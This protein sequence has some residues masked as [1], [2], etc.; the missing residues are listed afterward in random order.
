MIIDVNNLKGGS[1]IQSPFFII[2][3]ILLILILIAVI[4]YLIFFNCKEKGVKIIDKNGILFRRENCIEKELKNSEI[5][6]YIK[7]IGMDML[8]KKSKSERLK[9]EAE[10]KIIENED[11]LRK[12]KKSKNI[13]NN[14][15][16]KKKK[17]NNQ[18]IKIKIENFKTV[19]I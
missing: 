5:K 19:S 15:K 10:K 4:V 11:I 1:F 17:E 16:K 18:K 6:D 7:N 8:Q 12:I 3:I 9:M 14:L 13:I 2:L